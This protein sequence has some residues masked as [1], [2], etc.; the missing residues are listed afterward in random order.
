M[1][2]ASQTSDPNDD[3]PHVVSGSDSQIGSPRSPQACASAL[4]PT[5]QQTSPR[6]EP[7][8][9]CEPS[10]HKKKAL[11]GYADSDEEEE[12]RNESETVVRSMPAL[13]KTRHA[14][15][16]VGRSRQPKKRLRS[17][18]P[19]F[20]HNKKRAS[21]KDSRKS[22]ASRRAAKSAASNVEDSIP[23]MMCN[24][25]KQEC[26]NNSLPLPT[27]IMALARVV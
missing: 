5:T 4:V 24:R 26:S 10:S 8:S 11:A 15:S 1:S 3:G 20:Q 19:D 16:T 17:T 13:V 21:P 9:L 18:S 25:S 12:Y 6:S 22:A 27:Q 14:V 2:A 23:C 7:L